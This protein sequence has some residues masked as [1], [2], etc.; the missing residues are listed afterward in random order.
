MAQGNEC[1]T[2]TML[3]A[4]L[5]LMLATSIIEPVLTQRFAP[6]MLEDRGRDAP[7]GRV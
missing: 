6:G 1:W 5:V 3:N 7:L 2:T 4:V